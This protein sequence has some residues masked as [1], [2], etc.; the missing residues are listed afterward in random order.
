MRRDS[1]LLGPPQP[2]GQPSQPRPQQ[3][4]KSQPI[5]P[6]PSTLQRAH[7][8]PHPEYP[9]R[10]PLRQHPR[11]AQRSPHQ[12]HSHLQP[13]PTPYQRRR[14][15][16]RPLHRPPPMPVAGGQKSPPSRQVPSAA[17]AAHTAAGSTCQTGSRKRQSPAPGDCPTQIR[18]RN[19]KMAPARVRRY[20]QST[21]SDTHP[22]TRLSPPTIT[23]ATCAAAQKHASTVRRRHHP[24]HSDRDSR[25]A[26]CS[27][28]QAQ[29][30]CITAAAAAA[31][32]EDSITGYREKKDPGLYRV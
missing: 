24:R 17:V 29:G 26:E 21:G 9:Q 14:P 5:R 10:S 12:R 31:G 16:P 3:R 25:R 19:R 15:L 22:S 4:R 7:P 6:S 13:P 28:A 2:Q 8:Q 27:S 18:Q 30:V 23:T 32:S 1:T 20:L 11:Q